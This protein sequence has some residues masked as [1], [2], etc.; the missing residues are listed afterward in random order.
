MLKNI[1]NLN[2]AQILSK[3]EQKSIKG[4]ITVE[5][6]ECISNGCVMQTNSPGIGWESGCGGSKRIWCLY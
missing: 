3:N 4:G 2:G 6:A 1:L 5:M